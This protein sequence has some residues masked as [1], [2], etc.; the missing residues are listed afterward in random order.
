MNREHDIL[1]QAVKQAGQ[2]VLRMADEGFETHNKDDGSPVTSA[3]LAVNQILQDI[4][5]KEFPE[6]GWLSEESPDDPSRLQHERVWIIDPIDGTKY[7]MRNIPQYSISAALVKEATPI[8]GIVY[9]PESKELFS[10]IAGE[11]LELNGT[12]V[13]VTKPP[14]ARLRILVNPSRIAGGQFKS[15][16]DRADIQPM[17]SIAYTLA[18]VAA[19]RADGTLNSD[20]LHEWDVAAGW[21]LVQESGGHS[22]NAGQQPILFNRP[23]PLVQGIFAYRHGVQGPFTSLIGNHRP[24]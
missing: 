3:D 8:L 5:L 1:C 11:G 12:P 21:L 9:N 17:G 18:L 2:Q 7:F 16:T 23:N 19:G 6:D 22:T 4:L 20:R 10:A 15:Y 13:Q 14:P 24:A